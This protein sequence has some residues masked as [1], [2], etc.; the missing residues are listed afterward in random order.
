MRRPFTGFVGSNPTLSASLLFAFSRLYS[1]TI[2]RLCSRKSSYSALQNFAHPLWVPF[3]RNRTS[4]R[5][6]DWQRCTSRRNQS[7]AALRWGSAVQFPATERLVSLVYDA[8][9]H[10]NPDE[11]TQ[12]HQQLATQRHGA[13]HNGQRTSA[14]VR[15]EHVKDRLV[16]LAAI[17]GLSPE[18][19]IKVGP[20]A[21]F[22]PA[23]RRFRD[24]RIPGAS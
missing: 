5:M 14:D 20:L 24:W 13:R 10:F 17:A 19:W 4:Y 1:L 9:R 6:Q 18:I 11:Y 8:N 3:R 7:L 15:I 21:G 16:E 23:S 22:I 2:D 12:I